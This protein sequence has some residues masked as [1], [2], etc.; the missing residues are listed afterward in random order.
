MALRQ[1]TDLI[2]A[3]AII[4]GETYNQLSLT[5]AGDKTTWTARGQIR[6]KLLEESGTLLAEFGFGTP[7][8]DAEADE[9]TLLPQLTATQ[10]ASLPKTKWQGT[11]EYSKTAVYY[12]DIEL[13]SDAGEVIKTIPAIV[14]VI[15]EVTGNGTPSPS[16]IEVFLT[17]SNNLSELTDPAAARANLEI[18]NAKSDWNAAP[19]SD[20]EIL[21]KPTLGTAAATDATDYATAA[22]GTKADTALQPD[23]IGVTVQAYDA[24][25]VIDATYVATE[26]SYTTVEKN[27]LAGIEVGATAD[28][29]G[30]EIK[31]LYEAEANTNAFTDAEKTKLNGIATGATANDTDAN[32]LNRANH[33]GTQLASTISDFDTEV[34]NNSSVV[35]NTAKVS[36]DGSIATHSD[37]DLTGI[38]LNQVLKWDGSKFVPSVDDDDFVGVTNLSYTVS[39]TDGTIVSDTGQDATIIA[40]STIYASL[41]LPGDKTKLDGIAT[42]AEVNVQSDWN[43]VSGDAFILNKP[44][45]GTASVQD[46][47]YFATAAQGT[48]ADTALQSTDIADFE[49]TTQLN[50][51]DTANRNRA[52]HTGTQAIST[53]DGLQV[54][55]DGKEPADA[56]IL[57]DGD[58]GVTVQSYNANTVIDANYVATENSYTTTEKNKLAGIA[59]NATANDTDANL[60]SRA[61]HTGTQA[62]STISDFDTEVSNNTDVAANTSAR[63]DAVTV[64]DS[65]EIDFTLTGQQITASIV[66]G[67]ID[68]SKLDAS[69]NASL[70]LADSSV[71]PGDI[72][73][74]A[75][76]V[77]DGGTSATAYYPITLDW[78]VSN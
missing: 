13:E 61:N 67:S 14:Q 62:A 32:L 48:T 66:A 47:E 33:T 26:E 2:G 24:N 21:N 78:G 73:Q 23:D 74:I 36:A 51:R 42:G 18:V 43:A 40:G 15:G 7:T 16:P 8:Y 70:D 49:T 45:L 53:V 6:T 17:A 75:T 25:T 58:I 68:E 77:W 20:E 29:T 52:N 41:M 5:V 46:V 22:Q 63:H 57:K 35:A 50:T 71:Q 31:T 28:Q 44:T 19:G 34:S 39:E 12:W 37:V 9:T 30:A 27:K 72:D 54:A 11:G 64:V 60:L 4:Q 69:V 38:G 10:T 1:K 3:L 55:L 65:S 56:T 76:I 59:D